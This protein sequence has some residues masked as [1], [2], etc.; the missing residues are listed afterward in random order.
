[1]SIV[2]RFSSF[3]LALC[4]GSSFAMAQCSQNCPERRSISVNATATAAADADTA[5]VHVGYKVYG[6]DAKS[7]YASAT[8]SSN[9]IMQALLGAGVPKTAIESTG[10]LI[11]HTPQYE[12]QQI[13][14]G[15]EDRIRR[16][17]SVVQGWAARVKPDA[18]AKILDTAIRA[19]ANES[20]WI[21]WTVA[22][23]TALEAEASAKAI[24]NARTI[25]DQMAAKSGVHITRLTNVSENQVLNGNQPLN[26]RFVSS[27]IFGGVGAGQG[28]GLQQPLAVNSRHIEYQVSLR[29][30]FSI[31]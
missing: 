11:E 10:Q 12:L 28:Q 21:E 20:G 5:T 8:E 9:G 24:A 31:E 30:V 26:G 4:L 27:G 18:A 13:P 25:A 19:G 6:E 22:D 7:A 29:V 16:Q 2:A 14:V 23:P 15:S 17:F 3:A 1:M